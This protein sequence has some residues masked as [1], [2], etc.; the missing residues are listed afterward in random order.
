MLIDLNMQIKDS[1]NETPSSIKRV[2]S[3]T[4]ISLN[5]SSAQVKSFTTNILGTFAEVWS[6]T[7]RSTKDLRAVKIVKKSLAKQYSKMLDMLMSEFNTLAQL[8]SPNVMK[9]FEIFED[10]HKYYIVT[11]V[12]HGPSL[13]DHITN[14]A[15]DTFTEKRVA[16]YLKQLLSALCHCHAKNVAHRDIKP[17]NIMFA[18]KECNYLKLIDF[19]F[20]KI[21]EPQQRK[22]QEIL[23]SPLYMAPEI[24]HKKPYDIKCDIW[25]CGILA[26]I[27]LSGEMP[28][29]VDAN[30]SLTALFDIIKGKEFRVEDLKTPGW[31]NVSPEAKNFLIR[32]L[33]KDPEKRASAA[34]L[35]KDQWLEKAKDT[36]LEPVQVKDYLENIRNTVVILLKNSITIRQNTSSNTRSSHTQRTTLI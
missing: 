18:D 26:H 36:P 27:L 15:Q 34:D 2:T 28:Y 32:M 29:P 8:D 20:A 1:I 22:F 24:C 31:A 5:L 12:M 19:G 25:S 35:L 7:H 21:F 3:M 14:T 10:R 11:E 4:T 6:V 23:G 9:I 13:L 33:E 30:V 16:G 17:D